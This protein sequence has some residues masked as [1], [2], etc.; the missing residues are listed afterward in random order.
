MVPLEGVSLGLEDRLNVRF[1]LDA[2]DE[3]FP[4]FYGAA[5]CCKGN[6]PG[7]VWCS[8]AFYFG[9]QHHVCDGSI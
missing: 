3:D 4:K 9:Q 2:T 1:G 7:W 5:G 8:S 6:G